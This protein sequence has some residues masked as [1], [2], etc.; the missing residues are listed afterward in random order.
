MSA[1]AQM[2][3]LPALPTTDERSTPPQLAVV[4]DAPASDQVM[5]NGAAAPLTQPRPDPLAVIKTMSEE[6]VIALFT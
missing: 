3:P 6:E 2:L 4:Q 1:R 5:G